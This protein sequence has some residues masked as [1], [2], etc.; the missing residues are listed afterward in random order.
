[1]GSSRRRFG[2]QKEDI[3]S[4]RTPKAHSSYL[5]AHKHVR[6]SG[7]GLNLT[8]FSMVSSASCRARHFV[9]YSG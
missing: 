8:L 6:N 1:V 3:R 4:F 9:Q 5:H 2:K 7:G